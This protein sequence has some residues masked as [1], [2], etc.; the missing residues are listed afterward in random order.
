MNDQL[1]YWANPNGLFAYLMLHVQF[2]AIVVVD[3]SGKPKLFTWVT[4]H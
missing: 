1:P 2:S 4:F 3:A